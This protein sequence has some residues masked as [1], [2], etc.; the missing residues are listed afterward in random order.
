V[1]LEAISHDSRA[2]AHRDEP[3]LLTLLATAVIIRL[4]IPTQVMDLVVHY[5]TLGGSVLEKVHPGAY[6]IF[7]LSAL[8]I[9]S[10]E[11]TPSRRDSRV[12]RGSNAL[13]IAIATASTLGLV[14][15]HAQGVSYLLDSLIL[16]PL[17]CLSMLR[18][19]DA[20]KFRLL[21][22]LL[23]L[24][25]ANDVVL[26]A[27]FATHKRVLLYN[28]EEPYFRPT[29]FLGH[30]LVNGLINATAISFVWVTQ[31]SNARKLAFTLFF[32][33]ASYAAGAR[34]ASIFS[35]ICAIVCVWI[36]LGRSTRKGKIDEGALIT[37][38]IVSLGA[39]LVV[40]TV[41]VLT[42]LADRLVSNGFF[43]DGS[44][45]SRFTIYRVLDYMTGQQL[46]FGISRDWAVYITTQVINLP[47]SE[48]PIVDFVVEFGIIGAT[49]LVGSLAYFF[50]SISN[51]SRNAF[52]IVGT[53]IFVAT[54]S[55]NNTFS[56]KG[57]HMAIFAALLMS[58]LGSPAVEHFKRARALPK[59]APHWG[60]RLA[61][62]PS[63]TG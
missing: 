50:W 34:M 12:A 47:R 14:T 3:W 52:I 38:A 37:I 42:G 21:P 61:S 9:F 57:P 18:L 20:N 4:F 45:Q 44:S 2:R 55:T 30:P 41:V 23:L 46:L 48:S 60:P 51:V 15:G 31:W 1:T 49:I 43:E 62:R 24:L 16:G 27:E 63:V 40:I 11:Y 26:F 13:I 54:S 6:A 7:A 17:I 39:L 8:I 56:S 22:F 33:A 10:Q 28:Y 25:A 36:E 32:L 29:A 5:S 35:T 19:S 53:M 59:N 58:A